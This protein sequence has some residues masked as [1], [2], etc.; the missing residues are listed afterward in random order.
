M[1]TMENSVEKSNIFVYVS[2]FPFDV[3]DEKIFPTDRAEEIENCSNQSVKLQKFYSWKLLE[4]ALS[5]SLGLRVAELDFRRTANGKW[6]CDKCFFSLSHSGSF[7]AV[8]V[9]YEPVGID[10]ERFELSRFSAGLAEKIATGR[11]RED[12]S[13]RALISLWTKK[14]AIFKLSGDKAFVP[15]NIET[16][17]Y[18]TVTKILNAGNESYCLSVASSRAA[19]VNFYGLEEP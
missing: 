4:R 15:K 17:D 6:E 19:D 3:D 8:A 11:E 5:Q 10:I 1:K 9:S 13:P 12:I 7:V 2:R 18:N 16:A 14:E